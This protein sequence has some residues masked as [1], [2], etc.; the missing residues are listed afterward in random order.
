VADRDPVVVIGGGIVGLAT[1]LALAQRVDPPVLVLEKEAEVAMHQTGHNSGVIHSGIYYRPGSLKA[2][3]CVD[4]RRRLVEFCDAHRI[5]YELCGKLIVATRDS[6]RPRLAELERR[7]TANGIP[8]VRRLSA[9]EVGS[10]EPNVRSVEGLH[11]PVTGIVDYR[12]V[13]NAYA[14]E[15]VAHGGEI[16]TGTPVTGLRT[17]GH[18]LRVRTAEG[19]LSTAAVVNCAGLFSDRVARWSGV[20]PPAR[21]VPFRGEYYRLRPERRSV[22]RGLVYPVPDPELP[23]LGVHFTRTVHGEVEAGPNAVPALAREGYTWGEFRWRDVAET[24]TYRGTPSLLRRYG[25]TEAAEVYR[26]LSRGAF[27]RDLQR[28]VPS[29]SAGDLVPGGSGVRAQAVTP[30]GKLVDDFLL[31]DS[32]G[33]VHVLNAPSPAATASLAIGEYVADVAHRRFPEVVRAAA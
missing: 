30:D 14:K 21:I 12:V 11:V 9:T 7:A 5:P 18:G 24:L 13:S 28:M 6:E 31:M 20:E 1:A 16:R 22:V 25:R 4:G 8:G 15:I 33:A 23:F 17:E 26:S 2:R 29:L 27:L 10:V 32:P 19:W 3:L